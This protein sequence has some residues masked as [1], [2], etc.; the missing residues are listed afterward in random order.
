MKQAQNARKQRGRPAQR[1]GG[2]SNNNGGNRFDN[3]ARGNPKQLLEKYKT[4]ARDMLQAGDRVN[5]E[6]F[7][8][9][10]DHYQRLVNE[11][12]NNQNNQQ[13]NQQ[14]N[15]E[16]QTAGGQPGGPANG[17]VNNQNGDEKND[18]QPRKGRGHRDRQNTKPVDENNAAEARSVEPAKDAAA[19]AAEAAVVTE[20]P[21]PT[22]AENGTG[23]ASNDQADKASAPPRRRRVSKPKTDTAAGEEIKAPSGAADNQPVADEAG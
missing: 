17:S 5:A 6:Y 19:P 13:A 2:R 20:N 1:K 16:Q 9:F 4:Q 14:N 10:A 23:A 12:L 11:Q 21:L 7:L 22:V 15:R 3:R 18:R 8:Q